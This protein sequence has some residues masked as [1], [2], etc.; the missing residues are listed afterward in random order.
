M[1]SKPP[2]TTSS[3]VSYDSQNAFWKFKK[4]TGGL[5]GSLAFFCRQSLF[6]D[7][8]RH[9]SF[10][11]FFL[12]ASDCFQLPVRFF[13]QSKWPTTMPPLF[14]YFPVSL[15]KMSYNPVLAICGR[16]SICDYRFEML[17]LH[18]KSIVPLLV[19]FFSWPF[20]FFFSGDC[21]I[22]TRCASIDS[23]SNIL[24]RNFYIFLPNYNIWD[25]GW[26]HLRWLEHDT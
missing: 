19:L 6:V 7:P 3:C 20:F 11:V 1:R 8:P 18:K 15:R 23:W 24:L 4:G 14:P 12:D 17:N 9:Q 25:S 22:Q 2:Q 21:H 26:I 5:A 13:K 16:Y 10:R